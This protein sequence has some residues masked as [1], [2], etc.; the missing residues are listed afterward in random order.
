MAER[1][2]THAV[3]VGPVTVGGGAPIVIQS[4]TNTDTADIVKTAR[5]CIDLAA[6]GSEMVRV[7]VN[8]PE[9][10]AAVPEIKGRMRDAGLLRAAD[11]RFS[12]QRAR[13]ADQVSRLR[14]GAR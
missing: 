13:A 6:A 11:R 2:K 9:A 5:Q 3:K 1:H 7:T 4:M 10:A 14:A 8:V 12:L